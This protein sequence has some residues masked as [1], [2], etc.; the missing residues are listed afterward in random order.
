METTEETPRVVGV[1]PSLL[2]SPGDRGDGVAVL[3]GVSSRPGVSP[4]V[5]GAR[6]S[7]P[8]SPGVGGD[9]VAVLSGVPS[10]PEETPCAMGLD[11]KPPVAPGVWG[12][13]FAVFSGDP[14]GPGDTVSAGVAA[15]SR[16]LVS[17]L[18]LGPEPPG[19][20]LRGLLREDG[21]LRALLRFAALNALRAPPRALRRTAQC[22]ER[23]FTAVS[24]L[25]PEVGSRKLKPKTRDAN[26]KLRVTGCE[27]RN[28]LKQT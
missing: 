28:E 1:S 5:R 12:G 16:G 19:K 10:R 7:P 26:C 6:P 17:S 9:G 8:E 4:R 21:L 11:P 22:R 3:S 15:A 25:T 27:C 24:R 14:L 23:M 20:V 2:V 13:G 18:R